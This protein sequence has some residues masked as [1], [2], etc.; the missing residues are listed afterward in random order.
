MWHDAQ[1]YDIGAPV[2]ALTP[3]RFRRP[4]Y[5]QTDFKRALFVFLRGAGITKRYQTF[6]KHTG[7]KGEVDRVNFVAI[8]SAVSDKRR[9][10]LERLRRFDG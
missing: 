2:P 7:A 1:S 10:A 4:D 5:R 9:H 6:K 8:E 3:L